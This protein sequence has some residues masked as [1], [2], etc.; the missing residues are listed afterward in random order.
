MNA[1]DYFDDD[2]HG[3]DCVRCG[4]DGFV[5]YFDAEDTWGEDCPSMENHFVRCPDCKGNGLAFL[6]KDSAVGRLGL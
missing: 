1:D 2:G 6:Q 4:G 3:N 5:E